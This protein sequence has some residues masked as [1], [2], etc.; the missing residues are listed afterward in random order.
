M[1]PQKRKMMILME[2]SFK[3]ANLKKTTQ[4]FDFF[5]IHIDIDCVF[6]VR[7]GAKA[8]G[9]CRIGKMLSN[10]YLLVKYCKVWLRYSRERALS[11]SPRSLAMQ[12]PASLGQRTRS[13]VASGHRRSAAATATHALGSC[14]SCERVPLRKIPNLSSRSLK[15]IDSARCGGIRIK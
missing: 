1:K 11:S 7:S 13:A 14:T 9:S 8:C 4:F 6:S 3:I 2:N 5:T 10:E 12:Q 15:V